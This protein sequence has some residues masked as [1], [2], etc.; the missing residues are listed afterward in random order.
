MQNSASAQG[1]DPSIP[2]VT[3]LIALEERL[4]ALIRTSKF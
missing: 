1:S 4:N 2:A 3:S